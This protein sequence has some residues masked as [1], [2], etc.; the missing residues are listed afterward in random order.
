[1]H[2]LVRQLDESKRNKTNTVRTCLASEWQVGAEPGIGHRLYL[3][4]EWES[5]EKMF[6]P[7]SMSYCTVSL[8]W[9]HI[10]SARS[11][12]SAGFRLILSLV[13]T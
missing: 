11:T 8:V 1:M 9:V 4:T 5:M 7:S 3:I 6:H 13:S 2:F 10:T 12:T